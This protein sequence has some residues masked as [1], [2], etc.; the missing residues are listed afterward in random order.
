MNASFTYAI[1]NNLVG[2]KTNSLRVRITRVMN[3]SQVEVITCSLSDA[4]TWLIIHPNQLSD[5]HS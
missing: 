1:A 2:F 4:G 5:F 3:A